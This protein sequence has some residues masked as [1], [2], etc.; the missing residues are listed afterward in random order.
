MKR[1]LSLLSHE[2]VSH[3]TRSKRPKNFSILPD[4]KSYPW[5]SA[6]SLKNHMINDQLVDV[7]KNNDTIGS[8]VKTNSG[9]ISERKNV[10]KTTRER[11]NSFQE[12]IMEKGLQFEND[13]VTYIKNRYIDTVFVSTTIDDETVKKT[14]EYMNKGVPIIH[15]APV[16][17]YKNKTQGVIDLLIRSDYIKYIIEENPIS[18]E[19]ERK[20][21][22]K[23]ENIDGE[24]YHYIVVDIKFS[25]LPLK[26]D[27]RHILNESLY[28][29][30]KAQLYV[31]TRAIGEIQGYT[32]DYA[33]II[34]RRWKYKSKNEYFEGLNCL[35]R[36]GVINYKDNDKEY[37]SKTNSAIRWMRS[38]IENSKK[39]KL[40]PPINGKLY[41]NMSIQ[42]G[43]WDNKKKEIANEIGEITMLWSCGVKERN[44]ALT[45]GIKSWKDKKC[46]S[47]N[48]GIKQ[49]IKAEIVD[50]IIEI[51][52]EDNMMLFAPQ[53][54]KKNLYEW[55]EDSV[56]IFVDF[57]TIMDVSYNSNNVLNQQ[58]N[59]QIFMI[60][61]AYKNFD[62]CSSDSLDNEYLKYKSFIC[63]NNTDI[64]EFSIMNDFVNFVY[65]I[66]LQN[67]NKRV[68]LW[69]WCA[70][71]KFWNI[72]YKKHLS[73]I[74]SSLY[75]SE[76]LKWNTVSDN[77]CDMID[78]FKKEPVSIK[79]CFGFDLKSISSQMNKFGMIK[80]EIVSECCNGTSAMIAAYKIYNDRNSIIDPRETNVM[81]DI[82]EYN[83]FDCFVLSDIIDYLRNNH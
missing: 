13:L 26:C 1:T 75:S 76:I 22:I 73:T 20:N 48:L 40:L 66:K 62:T 14:I 30:Y 43:K 82:E 4:K 7:L 10:N 67:P 37:V 72:A 51:N 19:E 16:R 54:I 57:E 21:A 11:S 3:F 80:R 55:R 60:G 71:K 12:F 74:N 6:T 50:K 78:I 8:H 59:N 65:R 81:K 45:K 58:K 53:V 63:R 5:I 52:R 33:F 25:T 36:V 2:S 34:G 9:Y 61:V 39:W 28:K 77:W 31:Y 15:S 68:K 35:S 42:S 79:G 70:E 69:Y 47:K 44:Y 27:G 49:G 18:I 64:D 83:K 29:A 23:L 24:T 41:P 38:V 17:N 56:D 32:S 46:N